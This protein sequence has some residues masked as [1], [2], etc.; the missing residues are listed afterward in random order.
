MRDQICAAVGVD[1]AALPYIAELMDLRPDQT[2]WRT[3]VEKVL[4]GVGLRLLVPDQHWAAVLRFVNETNMRRPAAA[5]PRPGQDARR[6]SGGPRAEHV[7]GQ[8]VRRRSRASVRRRGRRRHRRRRRPRLR[9]HP[10]RVRPVPSRG[11]RHRAVQGLRPARHQGRPAS[12]QAVGVPVPG[13]RLRQDQRADRRSGR[14]RGGLPA[15]AAHRRR[16]RRR[17]ASSGATARRRARRSAS[18][19]R[20]GVRSTP[21]PPTGTPTGCA[22]STSCCW[23]TIPTSRPSTRAPTNAGRRSRN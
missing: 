3:A 5:A 10:R 20:S 12:A 7:G 1:A 15:G 2:R 18:S 19:S 21:R 6:R 8:A 17:S 13:R 9:R 14:G 16:H 11:H 22:N 23:P 4:R